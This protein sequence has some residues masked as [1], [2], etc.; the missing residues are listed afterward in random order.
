MIGTDNVQY[1]LSELLWAMAQVYKSYFNF[2]EIEKNEITA[3]EC[4]NNE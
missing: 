1:E 3:T 2:H 4:H